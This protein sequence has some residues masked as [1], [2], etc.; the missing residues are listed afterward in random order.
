[1]PDGG[2]LISPIDPTDLDFDAASIKK[3]EKKTGVWTEKT[4]FPGW[5]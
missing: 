1:L 5:S 2:I 3:S 4:A